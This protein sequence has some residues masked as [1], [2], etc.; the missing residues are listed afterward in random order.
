MT[1]AKHS[2]RPMADTAGLWS[3]I[4]M[5]IN[6]GWGTTLRMLILLTVLG[7]IAIGIIVAVGDG[8]VGPAIRALLTLIR[9]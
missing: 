1:T 8:P 9:S 6:G 4:T 5:A 3:A 2:K 7:A